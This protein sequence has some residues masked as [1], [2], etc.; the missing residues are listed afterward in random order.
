VRDDP[1]TKRDSTPAGEQATASFSP[2]EGSEA[3]T[4]PPAATAA[5]V[6]SGSATEPVLL[7]DTS[8]VQPSCAIPGYEVLGELGRGGM[9]VVYKARHLKL[10]RL[11]ALKTVMTRR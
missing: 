9:G 5:Y 10:Q 8:E 6:S 3:G 2:Q 7:S 4:L 11:V 1:G